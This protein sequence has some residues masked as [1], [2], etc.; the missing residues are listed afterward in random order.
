MFK[1]PR[2]LVMMFLQYFVQGAWNMVIGAVLAAYG[3]KEIVGST[4]SVLGIATIISPLFIGM[5]ADRFIASQKVMGILHILNAVVLFLIP[6]FVENGNIAG[7]LIMIFIVGL[8]FYP[9]T[10][11]AN[12]VSFRHI[13]G[14]RWFPI[15]R[16]FGTIGFMI[17]GLILG[18]TG[19][20]SSINSFL[21]ASGASVVY[22][23]YCFTL[24][25]T[26]PSSKN[27]KFSL[28]DA[29][30]LDA[31]SLF[32]DKY[33]TIFMLST[34]ILMITKTAYSA[35][36]PVYLPVL[37]LE[38]ASMMQIAIATEVLFMFLLSFLLGRFGFKKIILFGAICWVIRSLMLSLAATAD[39]ST[40][41]FYIIGTLLL[42]GVCWDFF[43]TAGDIYVDKKAGPEIKAQAQ[44]LRFIVSNGFGVF[45]AAS[46]CGFINN[47]VVTEKTLPNAGPQWQE[48]WIYPA[49]VAA[50]VAIG[51]WL[52]F[53]DKDVIMAPKEKSK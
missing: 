18:Y 3:L 8:L 53:K 43:F 23:I 28:R 5:I 34:F 10:A 16:V 19:F 7:F 44:G 21:L 41:F 30:C 9:T 6:N 35:Y 37:G 12:S 50:I 4:Y 51:F 14:V 42:Q 48:F 22:G 11:L 25:N 36:L 17:V 24:P 52:L 49:V 39:G 1:I 27:K 26:P 31:L 38:P 29:M 47:R 15:I 40:M 32:K 20:S 33:F 45:M 46:V 2:L 13:D